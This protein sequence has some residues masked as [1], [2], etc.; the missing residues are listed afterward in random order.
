MFFRP[1]PDSV[2]GVGEKKVL[3]HQLKAERLPQ[4]W[5]VHENAILSWACVE[6]RPCDKTETVDCGFVMFPET[7]EDVLPCACLGS[8][9]TVVRYTLSSLV[10]GICSPFACFVLAY[11]SCG[12]RV[13]WFFQMFPVHPDDFDVSQ[14]KAE[15][16]QERAAIKDYP[17]QDRWR[18]CAV[19]APSNAPDLVRA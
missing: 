18:R 1:S 12:F 3:F 10:D 5:H 17:S 13:F 14:G 9:T 4:S 2:S 19:N 6:M 16:T 8:G 15:M 11:S 7:A